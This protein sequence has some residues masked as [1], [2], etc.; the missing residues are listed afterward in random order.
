MGLFDN[1]FGSKSAKELTKAEAFAGVLLSAVAS[2]GHISDEEIR[3]LSTILTRMRLYDNWTPDKFNSMLNR[4]L[5][6]LKREGPD[7]VLSRCAP[8]LPEKIRETAFAN[9]CDLLLADGGI[10]DA[11]KDF[12]DLLQKKLEISGDQAITIVEVMVVKNRG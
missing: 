10:E 1:L 2:D 4:L 12:L 3:G 11:E 5:G 8:I 7:A 9:A 6:M